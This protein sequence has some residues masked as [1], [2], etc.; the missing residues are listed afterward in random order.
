MPSY[1][2]SGL[3]AAAPPALRRPFRSPVT[4]R[5]PADTHAA[6]S[7]FQRHWRWCRIVVPGLVLVV[8][9][10]WAGRTIGVGALMERIILALRDA[11]APLFF[12]AMA[13]LP[14]FGF[15]LLPFALA[16][17]PVFVPVLGTA[18]V[19]ACAI[20]AVSLNVSLSYALAA[21][22]LRPPVQWLLL[23]FGY[24]LPDGFRHN[25]WL[26]T[27]LVRVAPAL[28]FWTQ[29]Y[30]LGLV[31]VRFVAY[32]VVSS[33]VPAAYLTGAI[34]FGDAMLQ[35]K[36]GAAFFAASLLLFAAAG[37]YFLRRRLALAPR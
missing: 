8:A 12:A 23:R 4:L 24:A 5:N 9:L 37:L 35:R 11:G 6:P 21:T 1:V 30:L 10:V 36:T 3:Q 15:P 16:A 33:L 20:A 31:R 34:V 14:A 2:S 17:G 7:P 27:L 26:L 28:P 19:C 22:A 32:L 18:G 13:V 29:S 25:A